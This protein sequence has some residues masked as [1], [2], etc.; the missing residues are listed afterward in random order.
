MQF[1]ISSLGVWDE[2]TLVQMLDVPH[3]V[4]VSSDHYGLE[5]YPQQIS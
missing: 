2:K 3:A 4:G 1:W 5:M